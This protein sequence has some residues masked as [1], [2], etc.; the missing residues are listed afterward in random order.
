VLWTDDRAAFL[1]AVTSPRRTVDYRVEAVT[2]SG[3]LLGPVPC[4]GV[5][6]S[7][8]GEQAESWRAD[9][10]LSD[11]T[12][13]PTSTRSWLDGRSGTR[14]RVWWQLQTQPPAN[15]CSNPGFEVDTSGWSVTAPVVSG[16]GATLTRDTTR[17][18]D[19]AASGK[20]VAAS[21]FQ[22]MGW[23]LTVAGG[24]TV[25]AT[26]RVWAA[27]GDTVQLVLRDLSAGVSVAV[28]SVTGTSTWQ[29]ATVSGTVGAASTS[30]ALRVQAAAA[31]TYWVDQVT[32]T[33]TPA[34]PVWLEVP[35]GTYV[36]ED[37]QVRDAGLLGITVPGLDPLAVAR[38]GRYGAAV[39]DVGGLTVTAALTRLFGTL[40]PGF[41]VSID[42]SSETLPASYQ[43][44]DRDP[45]EDWTEIAAM[46]G[47]VVRTDR[48]GVIT[49]RRPV[50]PQTVAADWQEG[51][52][53]PVVDLSSTLKTSTIPRRVVVVST[54]P[55]VTP[56]VV[57][58]WVNPDA[59]S[60]MI[61][62]EQRVESSTVTSVAGA[63]SLARLTGERWARPQQSVEVTV[64][65]R[66]DLDYRDLI[67]LGRVQAG[68]AGDFRLSGW[69]MALSSRDS[70]PQPM[71]VTM[72]TR[73]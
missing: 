6:V 12:M 65:A 4:D 69:E 31:Q 40:V 49:C 42:A 26:A 15:L 3:R 63:E 48:Y 51:P 18:A 47:M 29:T 8:Q 50:T 55:D 68:V 71:S 57:G 46:A 43:L 5:R 33:A 60:Q 61:V 27:T 30:A 13:V 41:P 58:V 44:W 2:A 38:R 7:Y 10:A 22:G 21:A 34:V 36:V 32:I 16:T 25:T 62:T 14:L 56:P 54:S 52:S 24:Q 1:A 72:M 59:D 35:C 20:V 19:G 28:A 53:C 73:Q 64:P 17:A 23:P 45:A 11:L 66:P 67:R 70:A 39:V 37:P 9:F